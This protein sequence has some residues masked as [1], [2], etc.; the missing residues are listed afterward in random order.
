MMEPFKCYSKT[1]SKV[2]NSE[3]N[4]TFKSVIK[5]NYNEIQ[6]IFNKEGSY[7]CIRTW[8]ADYRRYKPMGIAINTKTSEIFQF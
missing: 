3:F 2:K 8:C 1:L 7:Y 4:L 6:Y 5:V